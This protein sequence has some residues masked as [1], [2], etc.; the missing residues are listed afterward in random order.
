M[1]KNLTQFVGMACGLMKPNICYNYDLFTLISLINVEFGI[2]MEGVQKTWRV[3]YCFV[4]G[5]I[6]GKN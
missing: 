1:Y 6:F 2:N 5:G 3:D 4:V